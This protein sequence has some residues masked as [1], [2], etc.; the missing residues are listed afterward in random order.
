M[1]DLRTT[2]AG[3]I[4][5]GI[6]LFLL[7]FA[8]QTN[9]RYAWVGILSVVS[10]ISFFAWLSAYRRCITIDDHPTARVASAPQGYVE[11]TGICRIPPGNS[12]VSLKVEELALGV[13]H[14]WFRYR[15]DERT[16]GN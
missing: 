1:R 4:T 2:Y 9:S 7:L 15:V 3:I 10:A 6:H 8:A 11:L 5:S 14:A 16:R 13:G 12:P